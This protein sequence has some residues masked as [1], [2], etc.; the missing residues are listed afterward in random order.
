MRGA[1]TV[2]IGFHL[3]IAV[4][5]WVGLPRLDRSPPAVERLKIIEMVDI[6]AITN[7]PAKAAPRPEK[8]APPPE[9][10]A[11]KPPPPAPAVAPPPP[12]KAPPPP[13]KPVA[14]K[15]A[16]PKPAPPKPAAPKPA[17]Q[18][19]AAPKPAPQKP[20]PKPAPTVAATPPPPPKPKLPKKPKPAVKPAPP[21]A[22]K[23]PT[24]TAAVRPVA[25]PK[26]P[27]P[28]PPKPKK[29]KK[30]APSAFDKLL[31][32]VAKMK[33][34]AGDPAARKAPKKPPP[35]TAAAPIAA[36]DRRFNPNA[37]LS[38]SELDA[39]RD[40]IA[41]CWNIPA[42]AKGAE[43][44]IVDIFVRMNPDG[45]VRAAEVTDKS[46]MRVDPFFRTAAE[47]AIRALRNPR[48]SPL[49]LPLDKYDLWKT[50][51]IGFNPRDMLG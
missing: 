21:K 31:R 29:A 46:R 6:A 38:V 15:T 11:A 4:L 49:R 17:P 27:Q 8:P 28:K 44:L 40:Q 42:G 26:P 50:F 39:I 51:T 25:R 18:K 30:P 22:E 45:T 20:K 5:M 7:A 19:P 14:K 41:D 36:P 32:S 35:Q 12:V 37:K 48:C 10:V 13:K 24:A 9:P 3:L 1:L 2:S 43:D 23:P 34:A 47:S 33:P 16:S